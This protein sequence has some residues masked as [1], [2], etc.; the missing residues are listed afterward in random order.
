MRRIADR[1]IVSGWG[2]LGGLAVLAFGALWRYQGIEGHV[3][4]EAG[5]LP[6]LRAGDVATIPLFVAAVW[7]IARA[8]VTSLRRRVAGGLLLAAGLAYPLFS[9]PWDGRVV[10]G[11]HHHGIHNTDAFA[12]VLLVASLVALMIERTARRTASS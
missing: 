1:W 10:F 6:Q 5:R 2:L 4:V 7:L 8:F 11:Q 3:Y 9:Y 12:V